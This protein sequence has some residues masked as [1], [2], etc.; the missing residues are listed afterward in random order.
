MDKQSLLT[1]IYYIY[2]ENKKCDSRYEEVMTKLC[3]NHD[4]LLKV[5]KNKELE[6]YIAVTDAHNEYNAIEIE[7]TYI[8]GIKIGFKLAME[9]FNA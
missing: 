1:E 7:D 8:D 9:I 6:H 2:L 5:L 4:Y 3:D